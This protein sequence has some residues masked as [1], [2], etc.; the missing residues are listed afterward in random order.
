MFVLRTTTFEE[1][2]SARIFT[3]YM[4]YSPRKENLTIKVSSRHPY[5]DLSRGKK[6]SEGE[7]AKKKRRT[8][9]EKKRSDLTERQENNLCRA[10]L[11]DKGKKTEFED[12]ATIPFSAED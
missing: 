6:R 2:T 12:H 4:A 9:V 10:C 7:K 11:V 3:K 5:T 1:R 8:G